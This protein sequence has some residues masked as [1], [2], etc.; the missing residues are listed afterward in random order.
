[1]KF[2]TEYSHIGHVIN[3]LQ[4]LKLKGLKS[5]HRSRL[6]DSLMQHL[7]RVSKEEKELKDQYAKKDDNDE[8]IL[9]ELEDGR[10]VY[11]IENMEEFSKALDEFYKEKVVI[12]G[13]D[14]QVF[15]KS[16]KA[17]VE[18]SEVEWSGQE[19]DYFAYTYE[20]FQED[21]K[22]NEDDE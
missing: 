10:K 18:E 3:V 4:K 21:K 1:M 14:S 7:E 9:K 17:S 12:D 13:G 8:P 19:S 5:I 6:K 11:D 15:L 20:A 2:V 22:E 16:V